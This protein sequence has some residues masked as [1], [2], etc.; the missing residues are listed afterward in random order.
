M[1]TFDDQGRIDPSKGRIISVFG[2]KGSGKSVIALSLFRSYPGDRVVLDIAGDDGPMGEDIYEIR[3]TKDEIPTRWPEWR[4][5]GEKPMTLRYVPDMRSPTY[6]DDMDAVVGLVLDR[7]ECCM[8]VHECL[9]LCPASATPP[10]TRRALGQGRHMGATTQIYCGP[11]S[12]GIN[13]LVM[14]Q[15]DLVYTL[16]LKSKD[17]RDTI[18]ENIGWDKR[19]FSDVVVGLPQYWHALYDQNIP[20]PAPGEQDQRLAVYRP[21]PEA[22]VRRTVRWAQGYRPRSEVT[23]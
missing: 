17:D 9:E 11:R 19:E 21:L 14:Q 10:N 16:E 6:L 4:R 23:G 1:S 3:G 5:D 18:A 2:R 8:L 20:P 13:R 22:E 15:S 7:G 12:Q